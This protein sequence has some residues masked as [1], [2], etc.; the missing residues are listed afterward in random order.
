MVSFFEALHEELNL[1]ITEGVSEVEIDRAQKLIK[2]S[3]Y[4]GM[5]SA[6]NRMSRIGKAMLMYGKIMPVEE[7]IEKVL[8]VTAKDI[9][10]L[11][12]NMF[13]H[14]NLSLAAIGSKD[15]LS[16]VEKQFCKY[17]K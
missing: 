1:F 15:V 11:A 12:N 7:V 6:T 13:N 17:F 9:S 5:E 14:K 4:L 10:R 3:V 16:E 8:A 2:S